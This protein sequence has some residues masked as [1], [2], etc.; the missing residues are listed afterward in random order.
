MMNIVEIE[1]FPITLVQ[2]LKWSGLAMTGGEAK[3][4]VRAGIVSLNDEL[5]L[6]GGKKLQP[7]DKVTVLT[8]EGP[9]DFVLKGGSEN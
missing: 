3:E 6:V 4:I 8:E 9:L 1:K 2:F 7:D 5:C